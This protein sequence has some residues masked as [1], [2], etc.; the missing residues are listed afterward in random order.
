MP[1]EPEEEIAEVEVDF[2]GP[3]TLDEIARIEDLTDLSFARWFDGQSPEGLLRK[4]IAWTYASR[5]NPDADL[6]AHGQLML[7]A[8]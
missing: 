8:G 4:V 2:T 3:F 7:R 5:V 1:K 6:A